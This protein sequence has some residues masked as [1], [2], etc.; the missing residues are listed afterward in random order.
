MFRVLFVFA[1]CLIDNF[2]CNAQNDAYI[3]P[4]IESMTGICEFRI[5]KTNAKFIDTISK[6]MRR[7]IIHNSKKYE[8]SYEELKLNIYEQEIDSLDKFSG[9]LPKHPKHRRFILMGY[10]MCDLYEL[11]EVRLD[12]YNDTLYDISIKDNSVLFDFISKYGMPETEK[13]PQKNPCDLVTGDQIEFDDESERMQWNNG[14]IRAVYLKFARRDRKTCK[15][16]YD[17]SFSMYSKLMVKILDDLD[18]ETQRAANQKH[19]Q[20]RMRRLKK[21]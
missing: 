14:D 16:T 21:L 2:N 3:K 12:F 1:I 10:K 5:G 17:Y 7:K 20:E 8:F 18:G 15:I 6:K 13:L 19:E 11:G 4:G 9:L